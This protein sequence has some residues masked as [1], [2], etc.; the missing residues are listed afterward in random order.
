M[1]SLEADMATRI[2]LIILF[3]IPALDVFAAVASLAPLK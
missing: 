1:N 2:M 3:A